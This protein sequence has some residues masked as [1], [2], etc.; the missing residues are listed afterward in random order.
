LRNRNWDASAAQDQMTQLAVA[1]ADCPVRP[2]LVDVR[3]GEPVE[4]QVPFGFRDLVDLRR[5]GI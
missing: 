4:K 2:S 5:E 1:P 3:V